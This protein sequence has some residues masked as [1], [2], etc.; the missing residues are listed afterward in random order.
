MYDCVHYNK[1]DTKHLFQSRKCI[2][3]RITDSFEKIQVMGLLICKFVGCK[4]CD[5]RT[6]NH[7]LSHVYVR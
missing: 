7:Q 4:G 5:R 3:E 1:Q 2:N 6:T